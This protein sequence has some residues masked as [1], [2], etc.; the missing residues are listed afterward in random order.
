[1]YNKTVATDTAL[2]CMSFC[3]NEKEFKCTSFDFE[4]GSPPLCYMRTENSIN[5]PDILIS[6][7]YCYHFDR[8]EEGECVDE[9]L[10][11]LKRAPKQDNYTKKS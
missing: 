7:S 10:R 4:G 5:E 3:E 8:W 9:A 6:T 1:M 2:E 11:N